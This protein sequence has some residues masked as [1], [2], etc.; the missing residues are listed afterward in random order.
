M[1]TWRSE[2]RRGRR[3]R[4]F[5][6]TVLGLED[7]LAPATFTVTQFGD[8]TST[9]TLR[10]AI[11]Q[12]DQTPGQNTVV[13]RPGVYTLTQS[14]P[15]APGGQTGALQVAG[16]VTIKGSD[17]GRTHIVAVGLGDRVFHVISGNV[18]FSGVTISGGEAAEGGGILIDS[19][20]VTIINSV[21]TANQADGVAGG[22]GQGGGLYQTSGSL[23]VTN[24]TVAGNLAVGAAALANSTA[25]RWCR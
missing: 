3:A 16:N 10:W 23:T 19:G 11:N 12:A 24:T 2:G 22:A 20:N 25:H 13:L 6:P 4:A 18:K 8:G 14:G 9:G 7:R 15:E 17:A 21:I 1:M 5:R